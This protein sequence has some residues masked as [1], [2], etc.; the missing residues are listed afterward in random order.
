[1][2]WTAADHVHNILQEMVLQGALAPGDRLTEISLAET[3]KVSRTPLR[4]AL[5]KLEIKGWIKRSPNGTVHV[6]EVSAQELEALYAV[7][8]VLE[9]MAVGEVAARHSRQGLDELRDVLQLQ[10]QAIRR[11][12]GT[13]VAELGEAFHRALWRQ[14]DNPVAIEFLGCVQERTM[15]YR[16]LSFAQ[17]P[18]F[19]EGNRQHWELVAAIEA[20]DA[21]RAQDLTR[22]HVQ[23]S[24]GY[25]LA[26]FAAW[27]SCRFA[28]TSS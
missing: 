17:A 3:L 13:Q 25:A 22:R 15:R 9:E 10:D 26:A 12:E 1:M 23:E 19:R 7:R 4:Q 20:V 5:G 11:K 27:H 14:S 8:V 24:R 16:R 21:R 6:A 2:R 28:S 18:R